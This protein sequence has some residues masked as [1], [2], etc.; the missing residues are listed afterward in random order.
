MISRYLLNQYNKLFLGFAFII[1]PW[2]MA[3]DIFFRP[4][5]GEIILEY[6]KIFIIILTILYSLLN[7]S[8]QN[9]K[10]YRVLLLILL[11][12]ICLNF[13]Y[14]KSSINLILYLIPFL[15]L[16]TN[17]E[18]ALYQFF[19]DQN[20][21]LIIRYNFLFL[22]L[23][24]LFNLANTRYLENGMNLPQN[25]ELGR[26]QSS[27]AILSLGLVF[28]SQ[29]KISKYFFIKAILF[30]Y[31]LLD[32]QVRTIIITFL[33][34]LLFFLWERYR[35]HKIYKNIIVVI[36]TLAGLL[37][38]YF[39]FKD[40]SISEINSLASGRLYNY[41]E[42]FEILASISWKEVLF[43]TGYGA[44]LLVTDQWNWS[45]KNSHSNFLRYIFEGGI[46]TLS[47]IIILLKKMW[48]DNI[49]NLKYIV[50][51]IIGS[52]IF[53]TGILTRP[54]PLLYLMMLIPFFYE[55]SYKSKSKL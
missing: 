12:T 7:L 17:W 54:L 49:I 33:V 21:T 41:L 25:I 24:L 2:A 31:L 18:K 22:F 48:S 26:H 46:I 30:S 8:I 51:I 11:Y 47:L 1:L 37:L 39:V 10:W 16:F 23:V 15:F 45:P 42:R 35:T 27:Y 43:G 28:F 20:K 34:L 32:Y 13:Y 5:F 44:D 4:L 9:L 19:T 53:N 36:S 38:S 6:I 14:N 29:K 3:G 52:S 50:L 40:F 55:K